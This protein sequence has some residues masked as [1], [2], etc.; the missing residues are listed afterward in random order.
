M[1][2]GTGA[3][4]GMMFGPLGTAIGAVGGALYGLANSAKEASAAQ[5]EPSESIAQ[6]KSES[7]LTSPRSMKLSV[8]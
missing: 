7:I 1:G 2:A 8:K 6:R 4:M 3:A 5:E